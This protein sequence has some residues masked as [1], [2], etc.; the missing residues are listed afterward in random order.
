MSVVSVA[1]ALATDFVPS[2]SA[3]INEISLWLP[4]WTKFSS[5]RDFAESQ[6][7]TLSDLLSQQLA[8]TT[9]TTIATTTATTTAGVSSLV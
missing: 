3:E 1:C 9:A 5:Q 7:S 6:L 2:K 4:G 8:T